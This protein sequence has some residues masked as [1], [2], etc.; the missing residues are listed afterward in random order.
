MFVVIGVRVQRQHVVDTLDID[1]M[2]QGGA[3]FFT[4]PVRNAFV[5]AQQFLDQVVDGHFHL[6]LHVAGVDQPALEDFFQQVA[7]CIQVNAVVQR[8]H[9]VG[10]LGGHVVFQRLTEQAGVTGGRRQRF[11][12]QRPVQAQ[13]GADGEHEVNQADVRM[14]GTNAV[15]KPEW[16]RLIGQ[17]DIGRIQVGVDDAFTVNG[18]QG[19]DQAA[20]QPQKGA[21]MGEGVIQGLSAGQM[22]R[23]HFQ[24]AFQRNPG[25]TGI[26]CVVRAFTVVAILAQV[27]HLRQFLQQ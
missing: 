26:D 8:L 4:D 1:V 23:L 25:I 22:L 2:R 16:K 5:E 14:I 19:S 6:R 9:G 27:H 18:L 13:R 21:D 15:I 17:T 20:R 11:D 12:G 7:Q 10:A 24:P 3:V